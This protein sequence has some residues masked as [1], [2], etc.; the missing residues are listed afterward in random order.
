MKNSIINMN[1][2]QPPN[3]TTIMSTTPSTNILKLHISPQFRSKLYLFSK[4]SWRGNLYNNSAPQINWTS[5][6]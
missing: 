3:Q 1:S 6:I 4:H 2:Y 5:K